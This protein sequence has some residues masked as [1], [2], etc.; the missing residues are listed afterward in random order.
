[1]AIKKPLVIGS[2]G[3]IEQLQAGDNIL[4]GSTTQSFSAI[5]ENAGAISQ[6]QVVFVSSSGSVNLAN[7]TSEATAKAIGVVEDASIA[8]TASGSVLTDGTITVA[9]WTAI[10][11]APTLTAGSV[12]FLDGVDGNITT[13]P[14]ILAG[15]Y[16]VRIG[17]AISTTTLEVSISRP[18]KL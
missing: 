18:I 4:A 7:N 1:M 16:V 13:I 15:S 12:Y 14:P 6:G 3:E 17:T 10:A 8:P 11:G 2:N 9:D 5:N